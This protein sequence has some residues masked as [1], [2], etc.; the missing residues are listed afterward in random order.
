MTPAHGYNA[1]THG[2]RCD[3]CRRAKADYMR[4]E[5]RRGREFAQSLDVR[6]FVDGIKHGR[7]GYE[8]KGCR[9]QVCTS[10][11]SAESVQRRA[12]KKAPR[13]ARALPSIAGDGL[14]PAR[15]IQAGAS[16]SQ[17]PRRD[18]R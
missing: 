9:C 17:V 18:L 4:E 8:V 12:K 11:H 13:T 7:H 1:Y 6:A 16:A 14:A 3:V 5:R 10:A 15:P 2:C